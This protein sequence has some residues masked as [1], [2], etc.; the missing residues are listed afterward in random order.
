MNKAKNTRIQPLVASSS[1]RGGTAG[2]CSVRRGGACEP[3]VG[4]ACGWSRARGGQQRGELGEVAT[5]GTGATGSGLGGA[6][7]PTACRV[8]GGDGV[9]TLGHA[10]VTWMVRDDG[11][12][13]RPVTRG[14]ADDWAGVSMGGRTASAG[15]VSWA[16]VSLGLEAA[17]RSRSRVKIDCIC[18]H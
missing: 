15:E 2:R 6:A 18:T 14:S 9:R 13:A 11:A 4:L 10:D 5:G 12:D 16:T 17:Q 1:S 3:K 8:E 7:G